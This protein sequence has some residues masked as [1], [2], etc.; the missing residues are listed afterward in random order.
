M[1]VDVYLTAVGY[2]DALLRELQ[3]GRFVRPGVVAD[4]PGTP[5]I[6]ATDHAF[7]RQILPQATAIQAESITK[8]ADAAAF[9]I[10]P[11][12]D[13]SE[14]PWRLDVIAPDADDDAPILDRRAEL[15]E[16]RLLEALGTR[17]KRVLK[18]KTDDAPWVVQVL[19]AD[20]EQAF[21]SAAPPVMLTSG[22]PWPSPYP[23]GRVP[24]ADDWDAPSSAFRKLI[25]AQAWLGLQMGTGD[26]C[27]DLG[28]APG[29]W[30]HVA[31]AAGAQ[32]IAVDKAAMDPRLAKNRRLS[33]VQKDGFSYMPDA[34]VDWLLSDIIAT[35]DKGMELI[36][37]WT[38]A[39]LCKRFVV[40]LKF[41]GTEQ[42][43]MVA[44]A[45]ARIRENG[46]ASARGKKLFYDKNE[47]CLFGWI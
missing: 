11:I 6:E 41:K 28:A 25:E 26:K 22:V 7:A 30:T 1:R 27:V 39:Q 10:V 17:R 4:D 37:R 32:V 35:P 24:V 2:E 8:L 45:L 33:H 29:G 16:Q 19:L 40:H 12:L 5:D 14:E 43:G 44:E 18:R 13:K 21:V 46:Y 38:R 34:P 15:I 3:R 36:D 42:Y 9:A 20:R 47:V 31:L 23:A